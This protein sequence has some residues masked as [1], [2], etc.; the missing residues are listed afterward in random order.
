MTVG[1]ESWR[2]EEDNVWLEVGL[3][4]DLEGG[5]LQV[6][7][8]YFAGVDDG[9][10]SVEAGAV[11]LLVVLSVLHEPAPGRGRRILLEL[12]PTH[13]VVVLPV[14][15]ALPLSTRRIYVS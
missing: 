12:G 7:D 14:N 15:L 10:D 2:G 1:L 11:I 3:V 8:A 6:K 4:E 13:K 5:W 9:P